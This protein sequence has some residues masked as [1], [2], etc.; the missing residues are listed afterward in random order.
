MQGNKEIQQ[1]GESSIEVK[2]PDEEKKQGPVT[3]LEAIKHLVET[4]EI[5][6]STSKNV[7]FTHIAT[8]NPDYPYMKTALEKKM[9]GANTSPTMQVSCEVYIVMKGIVE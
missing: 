7:K 3:I 8:T 9:V 5:P 1:N 4:Y 2:T 6:L